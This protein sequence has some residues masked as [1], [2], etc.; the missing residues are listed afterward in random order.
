MDIA[1]RADGLTPRFSP[2]PGILD[3]YNGEIMAKAVWSKQ[4]LIGERQEIIVITEKLNGQREVLRKDI[5]EE[6]S[7]RSRIRIP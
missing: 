2:L 4:H 7:N 6:T 3:L 1:R 5:T